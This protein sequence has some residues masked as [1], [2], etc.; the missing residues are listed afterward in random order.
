M[1]LRNVGAL[2]CGDDGIVQYTVHDPV[3]SYRSATRATH[4]DPS[5]P[6]GGPSAAQATDRTL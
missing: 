2:P 1:I 3:G 4:R 5:E 6:A